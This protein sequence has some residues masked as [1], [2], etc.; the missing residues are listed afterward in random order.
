MISS[1]RSNP[2]FKVFALSIGLS[3]LQPL[4]ASA[5]PI[6]TFSDHGSFVSVSFTGITPISTVG[7]PGTT[8]TITIPTPPGIGSGGPVRANFFEPGTPQPLFNAAHLSDIFVIAPFGPPETSATWIV[9]DGTLSPFTSSVTNYVEMD[10]VGPI[11]FSTSNYLQPDGSQIVVTYQYE[12]THDAVDVPEPS[13]D[14][15]SVLGL[16]A[17]GIATCRGRRFLRPA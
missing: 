17:M 5:D 10:N 9:S 14:L 3:A 4:S 7:C 8:C 2:F 16:V 1:C 11:V 15:L 12:S 13:S 6:I